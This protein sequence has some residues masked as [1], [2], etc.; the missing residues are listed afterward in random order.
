M[1]QYALCERGQVG[2]RTYNFL[3][4]NIQEL[5][6]FTDVLGRIRSQSS[7]LELEDGSQNWRYLATS[8][9]IE[10]KLGHI[11]VTI[12]KWRETEILESMIY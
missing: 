2:A 7:N 9:P 11:P 6:D 5:Q 12:V 3:P 10:S 8:P 1:L 4:I